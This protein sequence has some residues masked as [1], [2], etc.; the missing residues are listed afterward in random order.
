MKKVRRNEIKIIN[1][2]YFLECYKKMNKESQMKSIEGEIIYI[3]HLIKKTNNKIKYLQKNC[4]LTCDDI[5]SVNS[6]NHSQNIILIKANGDNKPN[7]EKIEGNEAE[8][9]DENFN[10]NFNFNLNNEGN[11]FIDKNL[12][13]NYDFRNISNQSSSIFMNSSKNDNPLELFLI[14]PK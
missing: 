9:I 1:G 3:K 10:K 7:I 4:Y 11:N 12:N 8:N 14:S 6:N 2:E 5:I 13:N